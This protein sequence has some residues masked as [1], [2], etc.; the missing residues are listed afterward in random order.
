MNIQF[1]VLLLI[2]AITLIYFKANDSLQGRKVC[3][4]LVTIIMACF[5]GFRSWW[6]GDLIKYYTLYLNC[7]AENG[8]SLITGGDVNIGIRFFFR[9]MGSIGMPYEVCIFIIAAFS[10]ITL[11]ILIYKYSPAPYW[12]YL[13]Y[14][15]MGFYLFTYSG[16]K[17][18][19]AMGFV[20]LAVMQIFE[21][22]PVRFV[23]WT[24]IAGLFH[25][26]A[27]IVLIAYPVAKK[28]IDTYYFVM[29]VAAIAFI[30]FFRNQII[31]WFTE[32]Y[33]E[34]ERLYTVAKTIG[35][36]TLM[37]IFIIILGTILRPVREGDKIYC[38]VLNLMVIAALIQYFSIYDNVFTR[39][40]DYY[41]QFI[42]LFMPMML[43]S[44]E[45]QL[46]MNPNPAYRIRCFDRNMYILLGIAIT[47]FALWF[48]H[49][50]INSSVM[51]QDFRFF[52][53]IDPY[54]LY[55]A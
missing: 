42:V 21:D 15:A 5:S 3:I 14:I 51:L 37:M 19:I 55:G 27:F 12:S 1:A 34:E 49:S 50:T 9:A 40:A 52:W 16:L 45:H 30:Y 39:L 17:Q 23:V 46:A 47:V 10:A 54:S 41:Y 32:A 36:R 11:G 2:M 43:E 18:T 4:S 33:Y 31:A 35:G 26:P 13:M 44:G 25:A 22:K 7:N 38:Q 8:M 24:M 48:Y 29:L 53:Q 20:I 6:M 28:K